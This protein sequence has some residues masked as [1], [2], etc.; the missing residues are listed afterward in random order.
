MERLRKRLA[1]I[2]E[3]EL[4]IATSGR[5]ARLAFWVNLYNGLVLSQPEPRLDTWLAR[6]AFLRRRVIMVAGHSMSLDSIEQGILRR[7][8]FRLG[9]GYLP[10]P[11]PSRFERRFRLAR[12]EPRMHFAL[13]CATVS[14]PPISA[15]QPDRIEAQLDLAT[16]SYLANEVATDGKSLIIPRIF[17]WFAGDFGGAPGIRRFLREH[18]ISG[19]GRPIRFAHYDWTPRHGRWLDEAHG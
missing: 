14:C 11:L 13:N 4:A 7:S 9:L 3:H 15:Y 10:N 17:L 2:S 18:G 12:A 16:R 19:A 1:D 8:Q 5:A 6:S